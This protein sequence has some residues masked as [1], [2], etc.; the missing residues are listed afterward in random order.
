MSLPAKQLFDPAPEDLAARLADDESEVLEQ[1]ADLVLK[2]ALDLDQLSPA[3][4][5]RPDLMTRYAL[6]LDLL[7]TQAHCMIR[8]RPR[9]SLRARVSKIV[10]TQPGPKGDIREMKFAAFRCAE[11]QGFR[12][13]LVL[14]R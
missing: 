7:G 11:Y 5:N 14:L 9:A 13:P 10:F 3:V 6:D 4:Q 2:I 8:A 12:S 1:A